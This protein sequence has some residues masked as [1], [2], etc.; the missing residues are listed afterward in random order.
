AVG[1]DTVLINA[2]I[3]KIENES[4]QDLI[5]TYK[6]LIASDG[7][8]TTFH[9]RVVGNRFLRYYAYDKGRFDSITL[10]LRN[11]DS[12]FVKQYKRRPLK[13]SIQVKKDSIKRDSIKLVNEVKPKLTKAER[14]AK[15]LERKAKQKYNSKYGFVPTPHMP[16]VKN[17]TRNLTFVG[18]D[19]TVALIK[20]KE[21]QNGNYEGFY[22]DTFATLDS[23]QTKNLIIDLRNNFGGR[24]NE[25]DY[26]YSYLTNENYTFIN[27]SEINGRFPILKSVM[28]NS[29]PLALKLV[30]GLMAP[31]LAVADLISVSKKDGQLYRRFKPAKEQ[32]PK[33]LNFKG[34]LYVIIN[35]NSF[36]ASSILST[37]L[38]GSQRAIFVGEETGGAYNGTVAGL[39]KIYELPNT[40]VQLRIGLAQV[41][42]QY[43]TDIDGYGVKPDVEI[44]PTYQDRLDDIDP[45]LEWILRAIESKN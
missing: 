39:F 21:F 9:N 32:E 43:K 15:K 23:L 29:N 30:A 7:Y 25:I 4:S 17:Y 40:K 45:E 27:K 10:T 22:D 2:E 41:D 33:P 13:D 6:R 20:I 42:S 26:F 8:N 5:E 24:L 16:E 12:T 37:Q 18:R 3:L 19:S 44:I 34:K 35:G 36:S 1:Q 28:T 31:G 11:A 14:K 38:K